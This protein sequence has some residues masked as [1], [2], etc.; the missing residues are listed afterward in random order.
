MNNRFRP[1]ELGC[2]ASSSHN[3]QV[4]SIP[5]II[6]ISYHLRYFAVSF[7]FMTFPA[8]FRSSH[9]QLPPNPFL[10]PISLL[11]LFHPLSF[12]SSRRDRNRYVRRTPH[13]S[14][15]LPCSAQ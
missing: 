11:D 8:F 7:M 6:D 3:D 15:T 13:M 1:P 5:Y 2:R 14:G 4:D 9:T 10:S 12:S